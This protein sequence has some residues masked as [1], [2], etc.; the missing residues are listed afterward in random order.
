MI[1]LEALLPIMS[2]QIYYQ[3]AVQLELAEIFI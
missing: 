2:I 1:L 3:T